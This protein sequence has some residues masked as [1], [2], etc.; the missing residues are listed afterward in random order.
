MFVAVLED[1]IARRQHGEL[2]IARARPRVGACARRQSD[3]LLERFHESLFTL[4][5]GRLGTRGSV[6]AQASRPAI[7][8]C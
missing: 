3:P 6:M 4:A 8:R 1:Q 5:D 2:P 7:P